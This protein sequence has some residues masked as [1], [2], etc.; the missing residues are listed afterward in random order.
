MSGYITFD[1]QADVILARF[2]EAGDSR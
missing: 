1:G 2:P